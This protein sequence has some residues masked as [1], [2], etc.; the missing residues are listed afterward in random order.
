[1]TRAG[2]LA[3]ALVL[4][5]VQ[6]AGAAPPTGGAPAAFDRNATKLAPGFSGLEPEGFY[7]KLPDETRDPGE[8]DA[9]YAERTAKERAPFAGGHAFAVHLRPGA[10]AEGE[11]CAWRARYD[12]GAGKL[13]VVTSALAKDRVC[14]VY[15]TNAPPFSKPKGPLAPGEKERKDKAIEL[16]IASGTGREGAGPAGVTELSVA[17]VEPAAGKRLAAGDLRVVVVADTTGSGDVDLYRLRPGTSTEPEIWVRSYRIVV[18]RP[19][20]WL[21][22]RKTGEIFLKEPLEK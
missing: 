13:V 19:E 20:A 18:A 22:D 7:W 17:G 9:D 10:G 12:E 8:S 5:L 2:C 3:L 15:R 16:K 4:P 14:L 21:F 6:P 1:M 11:P